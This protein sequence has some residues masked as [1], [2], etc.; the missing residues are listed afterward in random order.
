MDPATG[1]STPNLKLRLCDCAS[2]PTS[3]RIVPNFAQAT[4][5]VAG[6]G[7]AG[8]VPGQQPARLQLAEPPLSPPAQSMLRPSADELHVPCLRLEHQISRLGRR[9]EAADDEQAFHLRPE[10][11][12]LRRFAARPGQRSTMS[13]GSRGA[14]TKCGNQWSRGHRQTRPA[15]APSAAKRSVQPCCNREHVRRPAFACGTLA[16]LTGS[17]ATWIRPSS[18]S[19]SSWGAHPCRVPNWKG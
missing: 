4:M 19:G 16:R 14:R 17:T 11:G 12:R 13:A 6:D 2:S 3:P 9:S 7:R 18:R 8:M 10:L 1:N 15:W 5:Q